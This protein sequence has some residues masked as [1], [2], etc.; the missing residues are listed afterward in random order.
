MTTTEASP[1]TQDQESLQLQVDYKSYENQRVNIRR[2]NDTAPVQGVLELVVPE[3]RGIIF[4][5]KGKAAVEL[6]QFKEVVSIELAPVEDRQLRQSR[7]NPVIVSTVKRHI[8][9]RHGL[10]LAEVNAL[11]PEQAFTWHET[12]CDHLELGHYHAPKP[13]EKDDDDE[14]DDEAEAGQAPA[15]ARSLGS[16]P[17][18]DGAAP[19][20][21][22][23]E[24]QRSGFRYPV[25]PRLIPGL[26]L[27]R[28]PPMNPP[29]KAGLK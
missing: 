1:Q 7:L 24:R 21:F 28:F 6:V 25:Q 14:S 19:L 29:A 23:G 26:C 10:K 5:P 18:S 27:G 9:D 15:T 20:V 16:G 17:E 8:L 22:P 12:M 2:H 11:S 3:S 4:R 13:D